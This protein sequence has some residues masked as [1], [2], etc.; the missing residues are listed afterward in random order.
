MLEKY[1]MSFIMMSIGVIGVMLMWPQK[2]NNLI[3]SENFGE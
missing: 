1:H 3:K 2:S